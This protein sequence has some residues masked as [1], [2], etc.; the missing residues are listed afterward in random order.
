MGIV[1][2]FQ[3]GFLVQALSSMI[4]EPTILLFRWKPVPEWA[5]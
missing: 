4:E 3:I 5:N 2:C 1:R